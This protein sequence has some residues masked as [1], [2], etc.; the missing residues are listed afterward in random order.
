MNRVIAQEILNGYGN[1]S[2]KVGD[3]NLVFAR[4]TAES[5]D[6]IEVK[7]DEELIDEWKGLVWINEIYG[8]VSLN[9]M[10]RINLI[11]LEMDDRKIESEPL[12]SWYED[13][14]AKFDEQ[15]FSDC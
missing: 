4:Q 14:S 8:Q 3:T 2:V 12:K 15:D 5:L 13:E 11:E 10:Q 1:P 6:D 9:D 7:T